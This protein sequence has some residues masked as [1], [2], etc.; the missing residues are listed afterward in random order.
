MKKDNDIDDDVGNILLK[1]F[2]FNLI[3]SNDLRG[4]KNILL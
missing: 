4:G 3:Y 2:N 1:D